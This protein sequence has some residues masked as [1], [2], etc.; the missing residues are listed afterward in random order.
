MDTQTGKVRMLG[1]G[2]PPK[3][4]EVIINTPDPNCPRCKG[5]GSVPREETTR[6]ERRRAERK[7]VPPAA[8]YFPCPGCG[9]Y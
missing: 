9:G 2:E 5:A 3:P 6:A 7:G 1:E 8:D 4:T